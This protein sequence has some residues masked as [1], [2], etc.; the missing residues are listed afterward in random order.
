[1]LHSFSKYL[2]ST[3]CLI[4]TDED[5][6]DLEMINMNLVFVAI[7]DNCTKE[8]VQ[9]NLGMYNMALNR[10]EAQGKRSRSDI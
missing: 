6:R 3:H 4:C 2:S 1:M 5:T 9:G 8:E 10:L 7:G